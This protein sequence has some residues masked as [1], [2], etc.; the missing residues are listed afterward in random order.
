MFLIGTKGRVMPKRATIQRNLTKKR[1]SRKPLGKKRSMITTRK[2]T[3][4][5]LKIFTVLKMIP[6]SRELL[7][8]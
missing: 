3:E 1:L 7:E 4:E 5:E 2:I 8:V 6:T